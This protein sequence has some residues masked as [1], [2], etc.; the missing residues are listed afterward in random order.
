MNGSEERGKEGRVALSAEGYISTDNSVTAAS[1]IRFESTQGNITVGADTGDVTQSN[2][3][4]IVAK[5]GSGD[6][7][8]NG[9]VFAANSGN[10]ETLVSG[11]GNIV[12]N[13]DVDANQDVMATVDGLG[14]ITFGGDV[15][16][17]KRMEAKAAAGDITF[18]GHQTSGGSVHAEADNGSI[19]VSGKVISTLGGISFK[20]TDEN[21]PA[22]TD[23]GNIT[24][25]EGSTLNSATAI[26]LQTL[27]GDILM[28]GNRK[29]NDA[30]ILADSDITVKTEKSGNITINGKLESKTGSLQLSAEHGDIL[31][32]GDIDVGRNVLATVINDHDANISRRIEINGT[33]DA[34]DDVILAIGDAEQQGRGDITVLGSVQAGMQDGDDDG[35]ISAMIFG[36]G[37]ITFAGDIDARTDVL[38]R[39]TGS[40]DIQVNDGDVYAHQGNVSAG[41]AGIGDIRFAN[42]VTA[43]DAVTVQVGEGDV[44]VGSQESDSG[45]VMGASVAIT[46]GKGDVD[47]VKTVTSQDTAFAQGSGIAITTGEGNIRIGS[48]GPDVE[49]VTAKGDGNINLASGLGRIEIYGKTSTAKGDIAVSAVSSGYMPGLD[50]MNIII[51]EEGRLESGR[52]ISLNATNGD[53]HVTEDIVAKQ[54]LKAATHT[55][56]SVYFDQSVAVAGNV[57]ATTDTG[58][59]TIG[60]S[61]DAGGSVDMAVGTG[62]ITIGDNVKADGAV[63]MAV[64]KGNITVGDKDADV[65]HVTGASVAMAVGKGDVTVVKTITSKDTQVAKDGGIAIKTDEGIIHIGNNGPTVQTV[66]S[67]GD[68]SINLASDLGRVEIFGKTST[69]KGDIAVSAKSAEYKAG[70]DGMNIIIDEEGEINSGGSIS[71]DATNGDIHV[72]DD[73]VAKQDLTAV[74][75]TEG[76]VLFDREVIVEGNVTGATDIGSITIGK[77]ITAG[78]AVA[79]TAGEGNIT[80]GDKDSDTGHVTAASVVMSVGK[81]DVTVVKSVTSKDTQVAKDGGIDIRTGEGIIHI[82]NNGPTVQT[83][84][85]LGDGSINLASGLGRVEIFGKT[86]TAKGDIAVSAKSAEYK[87]GRDGM[88]I[89]IDEEG[90]IASGRSVML[91]ATN[92]DI[93]VTY[94]ITAKQDLKAATHTK[95]S[96][97]IDRE[98]AVAGDVVA[99]ADTGNIKVGKTI[100]A[101]GSVDMAVESGNITVGDTITAGDNVTLST[102]EGIVQADGGITAKAGDITVTAKSVSY[103][104][105]QQNIQ[106]AGAL[107]AGRDITLDSTNGDIRLAKNSKAGRNLAAVTHENGSITFDADT[108]VGGDITAGTDKGNILAQG[109]VTAGGDVSATAEDGDITFKDSVFAGNDVTVGIQEAGSIVAEGDIMAEN[110]ISLTAANGN[111]SLK[112]TLS[113]KDTVITSTGEGGIKAGSVAAFGNATLTQ[114]GEGDIA[115]TDIFAGETATVQT[116][117]GDMTVDTLTGNRVIALGGNN[118][119]ATHIGTVTA[120]TNGNANGTGEA[121]VVLGGNYVNVDTVQADTGSAPL[122][123]TSEGASDDQPVKDFNIR[124]L[125]SPTGSVIQAIWVEDGNIHVS[126]GD[127]HISKAYA[128][129]KLHVDNDKVSVALFGA[130]PRREGENIVLWNDRRKNQP[131]DNLDAWYDGAYTARHWTNIDLAQNG[132]VRARNADVVDYHDYRHF[133]GDH[134]SVVNVMGRYLTASMFTGWFDIAYFDRYG[135]LQSA[136]GF[137]KNATFEELS[138]E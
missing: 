99:K 9:R 89:I 107:D 3:G 69:A 33:V 90:E 119:Q 39:I 130:T 55:A 134:N 85:S 87:A 72:T 76:S 75:H 29:E 81:G 40:G 136:D 31:T 91:D 78:G 27:N 115:V 26:D 126:E 16:A 57:A 80:V 22:E 45:R 84:T 5:T 124:N 123:L 11:D 94:D 61:I 109:Q 117:N 13:G 37:D 96:V 122:T 92:G 114:Q 95:G 12:F 25:L 28:V 88:N 71:L 51:D 128:V 73:V 70:R 101:G 14:N 23:Q 106:L 111:I 43:G 19:S 132:H 44:I 53:I 62:N 102:Q 68:G 127:L 63:A 52:N 118:T 74:T 21:V 135:M 1:D 65:G 41:I 36:T 129:D 24:F 98:I 121:D 6:I 46:V 54:D 20:A 35:H 60:K 17:I 59:V 4:S 105:G 38:A 58:S 120:N 8:I 86:S 48:N 10:V 34:G 67:L 47:I 83:V 56:G 18:N 138:V 116:T 50:G 131:N 125:N 112:D 32:N 137:E 110:D 2:L 66:A 77:N 93:E 108:V 49:T 42:N 113:G 79:M 103:T 133:N 7:L 15:D 30:N 64:G 104:E 100:D 97:L 82:G